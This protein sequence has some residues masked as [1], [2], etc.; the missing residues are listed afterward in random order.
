VLQPFDLFRALRRR[1]PGARERLAY[2]LL[3]AIAVEPELRAL[4]VESRRQRGKRYSTR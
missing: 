1:A 3:R 2:K 4:L